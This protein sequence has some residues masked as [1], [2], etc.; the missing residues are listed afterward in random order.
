MK[1]DDNFIYI[2]YDKKQNCHFYRL[3]LLVEKF[4]HY[5]F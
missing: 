1:I 5:K 2:P 3:K 4:A